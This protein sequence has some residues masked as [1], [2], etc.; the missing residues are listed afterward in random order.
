MKY[1]E[2]QHVKLNNKEMKNDDYSCRVV[3]CVVYTL[4]VLR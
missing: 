2:V 4:I 1:I 3:M